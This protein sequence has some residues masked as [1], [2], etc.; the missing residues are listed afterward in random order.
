MTLRTL[1]LGSAAALVTVGGAQA[2]DL[3]AEPVNYVKIC[4]AF[5]A[6]YFYAPGTDTCIKLSGHVRFDI[7]IPGSALTTP[8]SG[9]HSFQVHAE[10][11]I[12]A[13]TMTEYGPMIG[14]VNIGFNNPATPAT[15]PGQ[16]YLDSAILSL[17]PLTAGYFG[18]N[19]QPFTQWVRFIKGFGGIGVGDGP[20]VGTGGLGFNVV[21]QIG[22]NWA[23]G[24]VGVWIAAEDY[25]VRGAFNGVTA[26]GNMPDITGGVNFGGGPVAVTV[27]GGFRDD[28]LSSYGINAGAR[29]DL[30]GAGLGGGYLLVAGTYA[31]NSDTFI[32]GGAGATGAGAYSIFGSLGFDPTSQ[33]SFAVG[34]LYVT[35]PG[36]GVDPIDTDVF[37]NLTFKPVRN[38]SIA[39]EVNVDTDG[40]DPATTGVIRLR[41]DYP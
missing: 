10:T 29:I 16:V 11:A 31:G 5:G 6:G 38:F 41:R 17:G 28:G 4:D 3:G 18:S 25:S 8:P 22:L 39:G 9:S 33:F 36:A 27:S 15:P 19:F 21:N 32:N 37:V 1:L 26:T 34:A 40:S 30:G 20:S 7:D 12:T 23:M 14:M 24:G 2:A 13:A 35:N